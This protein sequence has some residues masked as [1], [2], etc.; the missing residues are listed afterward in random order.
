MDWWAIHQRIDPL[1]GLKDLWPL[2]L[3]SDLGASSFGPC[4]ALEVAAIAKPWFATL[5]SP[6]EA[7]V[8][9]SLL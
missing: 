6:S 5:P 3:R 1:P 7:D 8:A 9:L 2:H 4:I